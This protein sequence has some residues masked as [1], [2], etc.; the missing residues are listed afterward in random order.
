MPENND[1]TNYGQPLGCTNYA[2]ER[3]SREQIS[4]LRIGAEDEPLWHYPYNLRR[5]ICRFARVH[6]FDSSYFDNRGEPLPF[7]SELNYIFCGCHRDYREIRIC[8]L[9]RA[10]NLQNGFACHLWR[11][12]THAWNECDKCGFTY[13]TIDRYRQHMDDVTVVKC[14]MCG[15]TREYT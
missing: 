5:Y 10:T 3:C 1:S 12:K 2:G 11:P 15:H 7:T 13:K 14:E 6:S 8:S 9:D 4:N